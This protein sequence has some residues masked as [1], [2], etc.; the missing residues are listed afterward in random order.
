LKPASVLEQVSRI[1][2]EELKMLNTHTLSDLFQHMEWADAAMWTAVLA[3]PSAATDAKLQEYLY[4]LHMVQRAFLRVW[5]GEPRADPYPTFRDAPSLRQWGRS[6]YGEAG[7]HLAG[8][9]D[10]EVAQPLPVP[11][12][13]MVEQRLGRAPEVTTI[14]ETALQVALHSLYHRGQVHARLREVGGEPPLVDYIAWVWLG[15]PAPVW[16]SVAAENAPD[17]KVV[18]EPRNRGSGIYPWIKPSR[19]WRVLLRAGWRYWL[20]LMRGLTRCLQI[21]TLRLVALLQADG[22]LGGQT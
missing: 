9:S 6:Y 19:G 22:R 10:A 21:Y 14:G 2:T 4:H 5:R 20:A 8:L 17:Y 3:A 12:A 11:W 7:A 16:P 13:A 1:S 15:R 18:P